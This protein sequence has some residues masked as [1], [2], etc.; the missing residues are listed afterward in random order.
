MSEEKIKIVKDQIW[1]I[2]EMKKVCNVTHI[3]QDLN[4]KEGLLN[5]ILENEG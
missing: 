4:Y 1:L 5:K 2:K 3:Y